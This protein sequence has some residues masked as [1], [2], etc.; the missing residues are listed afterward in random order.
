MSTRVSF[1][2]AILF[3]SSFG[4]TAA[5]R[6][7]TGIGEPEAGRLFPAAAEQAPEPVLAA[8]RPPAPAYVPPRPAPQPRVLAARVEPPAAPGAY[9]GGFIELLVTGQTPEPQPRRRLAALG[10]PEATVQRQI[11]PVFFRAEVDYEGAERPGTIVID[12]GNKFLYLVQGGGR[13]LRYG[14]GV[15]RPGFTWAGVKA[16]SRK[17]EWPDWTPPGEM[18]ARRPDLPRHMEGGPANP[19]GARAMYLGSSLYRI[20][21][22]NEPYTIGQNVSSGCIRMMNDD[23]VDLYDR[24]HVGTKVVVR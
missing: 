9:G 22:T 18:L 19:L 7:I 23:V 1:L 3:A 4:A 17:A 21:G 2:V 24:V 10:A 15:G 12:S 14:I 20:H 6:V 16:I 5:P 11:D 8:A 13:A